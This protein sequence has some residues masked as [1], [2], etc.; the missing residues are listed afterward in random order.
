[1]RLGND[2]DCFSCEYCKT[3]VI[4]NKNKDG[5]GVLG[6][7]S[8]FECPVCGVPLEHAVIDRHRILYCTRCCGSLIS[9]PVF[10]SVV[11]DLRA[12]QSGAWE[13]PRPPDPQEL[14]RKLRC[15]KC[16][17]Q[18]DTHYYAGPGNIIIDDCDRCELNWLDNGELMRVV[19]TSDV[20]VENTA[21]W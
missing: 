12:H 19:R 9:M 16:K 20:S 14:R 6:E 15:P 8:A 18:M 10:V 7:I 17:Q 1:M 2:D 11:G 21:S 3:L 13:I 5:I 4:P